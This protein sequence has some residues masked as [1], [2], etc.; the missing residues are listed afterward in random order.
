ISL[1][2]PI[3]SSYP[4]IISAIQQQNSPGR[5][6]PSFL[7][8]GNYMFNNETLGRVDSIDY[9]PLLRSD[10]HFGYPGL[11]IRFNRNAFSYGSSIIAQML[12]QQIRNIRIP[13]FTQCLPEVNG[14]AYLTN[15]LVT[16]YQC[17]QRVALFP[18]SHN[19][20][21]LNIQNFD[22][23]LSGQLGGQIVVLLPLPLCG[24][25]CIDA[26]QIS[27]SLQLAIERNVYNSA[28]YI[29]MTKCSLTIGYLN[30]HIVNGGLI[31]EVI[32]NNFRNKILSQAYAALPEK[33]CNMIQPLI[34]EHINSRLINMPQR[35]SIAQMIS[36][37]SFLI[38]KPKKL[39]EY[40]SAIC[41]F[42]FC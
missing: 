11:K 25:L 10:G 2:L 22:L 29:R 31:G 39:P 38:N 9:N 18:I 34:D 24:T 12:N 5:P 40:V 35:I 7:Q 8:C 13:S 3:L 15:I 33:F 20:I 4:V 14:C 19:E 26:R 32:N 23:S 30:I 27:V 1:L 42:L 36:Y 16:N 17:A 37:A 6:I 41:F 28:A 21:A